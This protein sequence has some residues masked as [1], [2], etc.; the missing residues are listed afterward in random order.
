MVKQLYQGALWALGGLNPT[1]KRSERG[2]GKLTQLV[3]LRSRAA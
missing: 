3:D 1:E 2:L